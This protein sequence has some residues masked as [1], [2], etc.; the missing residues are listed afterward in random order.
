MLTLNTDVCVKI[1]ILVTT[2]SAALTGIDENSN[3][4]S[5]APA[6]GFCDTTAGVGVD[7]PTAGLM[8]T[9]PVG[10]LT[11]GRNL[12]GVAR[13]LPPGGFRVLSRSAAPMRRGDVK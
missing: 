4:D 8:F 6:V 3:I 9:L 5:N 13:F 1:T 11:A 10:P 2:G 12:T 7:F